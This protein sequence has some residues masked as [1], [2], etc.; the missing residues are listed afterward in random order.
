[1]HPRTK[2]KVSKASGA[3]AM[4]KKPGGPRRPPL[5][6]GHAL[7]GAALNFGVGSKL[8]LAV[9]CR[10]FSGKGERLCIYECVS[11]VD[12]DE[13]RDRSAQQQPAGKP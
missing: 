10:A 13:T 4:R 11:G 2:E 6:F 9:G 12:I 7:P 8:E 3:L 5:P 1:M